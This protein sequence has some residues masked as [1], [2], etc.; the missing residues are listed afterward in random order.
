MSLLTCTGHCFRL[1]IECIDDDDMSY[2]A[3]ASDLLDTDGQVSYVSIINYHSI[4][5]AVEADKLTSSVVVDLTS[6]LSYVC[7]LPVL[8]HLTN[9]WCGTC[10]FMS[11]ITG[12]VSL[13]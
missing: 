8:P 5:V 4:S 1:T 10:S 9:T 6:L 2:G 13:H 7:F 3:A 12:I 11:T